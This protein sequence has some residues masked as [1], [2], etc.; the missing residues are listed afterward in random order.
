VCC[1]GTLWSPY[2]CASRPIELTLALPAL[3][4]LTA[5]LCIGLLTPIICPICIVALL[6]HA[7][8][9]ADDHALYQFLFA[10]IT[11]SL[12]MLGPGAYSIDARLFG[13]R[14][15]PRR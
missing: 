15:I 3:A 13:R 2:L 12:L 10:L 1:A 7:W 11:L 9:Q 4:I 14:V 8:K 5:L 6:S